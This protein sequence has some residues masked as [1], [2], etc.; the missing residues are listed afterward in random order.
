[1]KLRPF[2]TALLATLACTH[3]AVA[4]DR[5]IKVGNEFDGKPFNFVQ[6]GKYVGFD[7]DLLAE[8]AKE[9]GFQ[10]QILPMEFSALVGK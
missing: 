2:L 3:A 6:D 1:M 7:Q 4:Q 9:A 5:T 8:I 10:V